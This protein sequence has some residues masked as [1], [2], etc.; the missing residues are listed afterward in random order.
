M[1]LQNPIKM[2]FADEGIDI[3]T[4]SKTIT[5]MRKNRNL[6]EFTRCVNEKFKINKNDANIYKTCTD[7]LFKL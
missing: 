7:E 2:R 1:S 5:E 4:L 3:Q 6:I